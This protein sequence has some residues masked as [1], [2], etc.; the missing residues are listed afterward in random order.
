MNHARISLP[1]LL[2]MFAASAYAQDAK[3]AAPPAQPA[4]TMSSILDRQLSGQEK[5]IVDAAAAMPEEK[6]N[7]SPESL[8][9][10]GSDYK[11]VRTFA[12][13][14]KHIATANYIFWGAITGDKP[15]YEI[16]GPNG[17]DEIKTKAD[18]LK[19][20]KDSFAVGHKAVATVTPEN[21]LEMLPF[22]ANKA[23]RI[24]LVSNELIHAND[25]YGQMVEYLRMN[26]V[27]P[28]ASRPQN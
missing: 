15:A 28:P 13:E 1:I 11:G 3:P 16:K 7:F 23:P 8:N 25:H 19:Y 18:I 21:L 12:M 9:I 2:L 10:S 5:N 20:L 14:V 27:V 24:G 22:R 6:Y 4:P 26:G 17:P